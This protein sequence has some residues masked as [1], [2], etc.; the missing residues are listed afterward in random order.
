MRRLSILFSLILVFA[1]AAPAFAEQ[2]LA[3]F[4][5]REITTRCE[6][7][8]AE[9]QKIEKQFA[10]ERASLQQLEATLKK[11]SE[12]LRVQAGALSRDA[13]QDRQ[14]EIVR[15][16]RD[17]EDAARTLARKLEAEGT[18]IQEEIIGLVAEAT[19]NYAEKNKIDIVL[20]T[21]MAVMYASDTV[22]ITEPI[23]VE[24]NAL[25]KAKGSK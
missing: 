19:K 6:K 25:W 18:R 22:N 16:Q 10:T 24:V 7:S 4:S 3:V 21:T 20:E 15:L 5:L 8:V 1:V 11:K 14:T 17:Y 9:R 2:K 23:L 12:D 13:Q